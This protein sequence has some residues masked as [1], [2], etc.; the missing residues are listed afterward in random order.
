MIL[1]IL[2]Y[3]SLGLVLGSWPV[4]LGTMPQI[5][6]WIRLFFIM[7]LFLGID[8]AFSFMGAFLTVLHDT[9]FNKGR[10]WATVGLAMCAFLFSESCL[11]L[12]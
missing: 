12:F 2:W 11:H 7:L 4:A 6:H 9:K 10:K 5:G 8:S 3:S 1:A